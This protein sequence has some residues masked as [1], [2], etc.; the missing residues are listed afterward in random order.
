MF[1]RASAA[2]ASCM[3]SP[4]A[5]VGVS[6]DRLCGAAAARREARGESHRLLERAGAGAALADDV[7]GGAVRG[8][9]KD[10]IE[11]R[12]DG[13]PAVEALQLGRDLALVVVH[14][15]HAVE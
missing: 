6:G 15:E 12:R 1:A 11:A 8:C 5:A 13:D 4:L 3:R 9:R 10:G 7:E 14:G 2:T